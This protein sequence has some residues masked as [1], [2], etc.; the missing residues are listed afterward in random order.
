MNDQPQVCPKCGGALAHLQDG[1]AS[2]PACGFEGEAKK[3]NPKSFT[4]AS[5]VIFWIAL[6]APAF[7]AL[8]SFLLGALSQ[9][10]RNAGAEVGF[11]DLFVGGIASL[12][13]GV[14]LAWRFCKPGV[15]RFLAGMWLSVGIA[16]LNFVLIFAGCAGNLR[17]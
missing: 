17:F 7:L 5:K 16:F 1:I 15:Y 3:P 4:T 14:W 11:V 2:C 6:I 13:C 9:N 12:Y 10:L 8:V